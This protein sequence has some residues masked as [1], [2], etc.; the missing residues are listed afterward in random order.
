MLTCRHAHAFHNPA[1]WGDLPPEFQPVIK[2]V[3][4]DRFW[5]SGISSGSRDEF[6]EHVQKTRSALEGLASTI[7]G[8]VRM[9]R[10]SC[11]SILWCMSRMG[12]LFYGIDQLP[13]PLSHALFADAPCL[14]SHQ[15]SILLNMTRYLIDDCPVD[16]REIFL[17]P[18]LSLLFSQVDRKITAEWTLVSQKSQGSMNDDLSDE[19]KEESILRQLTYIAVLMVSSILENP[20]KLSVLF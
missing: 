17:T 14:S 2:K 11:Y 18:F 19:M 15:L 1:N 13:G 7:R 9:V 16:R 5:Q 10:E 20:R 3:L 12:M 4:T 6:Y 8:T